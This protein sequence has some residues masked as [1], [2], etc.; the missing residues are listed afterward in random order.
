M[1]VWLQVVNSASLFLGH[2]LK[3]YNV[4]QPS[5]EDFSNG[6]HIQ[7]WIQTLITT[8]VKTG[9]PYSN[10][11]IKE[12][13]DSALKITCF[14]CSYFD[15]P[16]VKALLEANKGALK[17]WREQY[18]NKAGN[19]EFMVES[20]MLPGDVG[21]R[22]REH[23][24]MEPVL[25]ARMQHEHALDELVQHEPVGLMTDWGVQLDW[26]KGIKVNALQLSCS[27]SVKV[28]GLEV[29]PNILSPNK[30]ISWQQLAADHVAVAAC[31]FSEA[32]NTCQ[33]AIMAKMQHG[34]NLNMELMQE[35]GQVVILT[36]M[37]G[38][39]PPHRW[40]ALISIMVGDITC[41]NNLVVSDDA[42]QLVCCIK[43]TKRSKMLKKGK[44]PPITT[45]IPI[46]TLGGMVFMVWLKV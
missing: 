39:L 9:K 45:H 21:K 29:Y 16:C 33:Q 5:L 11:T 44:V 22:G 23:M 20:L 15:N 41:P 46:T 13:L 19:V 14:I 30:P 32:I 4:E 36:S 25:H 1:L 40:G 7:E 24:E 8:G 6:Q 34:D 43:E 2:V 28:G 37:W 18:N 35:L 31:L 42:S 38:T 26:I 17:R 10:G 27:G 3:Y 12:H